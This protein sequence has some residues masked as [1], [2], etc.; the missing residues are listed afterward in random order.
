MIAGVIILAVILITVTILFMGNLFFGWFRPK[1]EGESCSLDSDGIE[2]NCAAGLDCYGEKCQVPDGATP[3]NCSAF[4]LDCDQSFGDIQEFYNEKYDG[5]YE[6]IEPV[7]TDKINDD[8]CRLKY[9][10]LNLSTEKEAV[11]GRAYDF[12]MTYQDGQ[13]IPTEMNSN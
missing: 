9:K 6:M 3:E 2:S 11:S 5:E 8:S 12:K 10:Y 4:S 1:L 13:W 7:T